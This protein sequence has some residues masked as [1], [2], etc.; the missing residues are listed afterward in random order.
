VVESGARVN[1]AN[2]KPG[3][4]GN[5]VLQQPAQYSRKRREHGQLSYSTDDV[6]HLDGSANV[7]DL[8]EYTFPRRVDD[9]VAPKSDNITRYTLYP[10]GR[11]RSTKP[12]PGNAPGSFR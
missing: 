10:V 8:M 6:A 3:L 12:V 7:Q 1:I 4:H 9:P 2:L 11:N 5:A